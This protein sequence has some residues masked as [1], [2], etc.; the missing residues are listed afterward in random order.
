MAR[1]HNQ[2][3]VPLSVLFIKKSLSFSFL[4]SRSG[5]GKIKLIFSTLFNSFDYEILQRL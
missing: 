5:L 4:S 3:T 2:I 1:L